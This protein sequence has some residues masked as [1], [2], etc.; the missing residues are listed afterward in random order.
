MKSIILAVEDT[1]SE[2]VLRRLVERFTTFEAPIVLGR[3][4]QGYL[5][6]KAPDLNRS[7]R[8]VPIICLTDLDRE[9]CAAEL[10][11]SWVPRRHHQFLLRVAVREVEAWLLADRQNLAAFLSVPVS[12][13]PREPE[14]IVDPKQVLVNLARRSRRRSICRGI[15]PVEGTTATQGP[16]YN[17]MLGRFVVDHWDIPAAR[18]EADSLDR[19]IQALRQLDEYARSS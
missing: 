18:R 17:S 5:K 3:Q 9:V 1:L 19:A 7:A 13:M 10:V 8:G 15:V 4:G 6:S 11:D 2:T 12:R 16:E 14:G